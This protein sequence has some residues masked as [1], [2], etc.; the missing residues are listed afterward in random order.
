MKEAVYKYLA[1]DYTGAASKIEYGKTGDKVELISV[2]GD[3]SLVMGKELF[4]IKT[5]K[6][7]TEKPVIEEKHCQQ[8]NHINHLS[9][10]P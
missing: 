4:H 3:M 8:L 7:I 6:L 9:L 5:E 2:N 1:E 10:I